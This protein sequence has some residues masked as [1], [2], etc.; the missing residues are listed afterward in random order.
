MY[1]KGAVSTNKY[2]SQSHISNKNSWKMMTLRIL[3][4]G[5]ISGLLFMFY[6]LFG[7]ES[8]AKFLAKETFVVESSRDYAEAD[9]PA[10][11]VCA[12]NNGVTGWRNVKIIKDR[13]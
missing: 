9:H 7:Q 8:I 10:I 2:V 5:F 1:I 6:N 12:T 3:K 4:V 13:A 11:T